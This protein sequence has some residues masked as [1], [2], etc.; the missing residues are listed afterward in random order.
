MARMTDKARKLIHEHR[1]PRIHPAREVAA[2]IRSGAVLLD[3]R[4]IL[5]TRKGMAPGALA[6]SLFRLKGRLHEIPRGKAI[7]TYCG[8]GARAGKACDILTAAG[9]RAVNGG[10]YAGIRK[11]L[12]VPPKAT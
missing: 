2:L 12:G 3:V 1:N 11:L 8:T 7:V 4:T 10:G 6:I 5:E 9:F